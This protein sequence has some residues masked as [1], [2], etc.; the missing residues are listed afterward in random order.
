MYTE[1][2]ERKSQC[3]KSFP[4]TE[5]FDIDFPFSLPHFLTCRWISVLVNIGIADNDL[6][7]V[8][9]ISNWVSTGNDS[10]IFCNRRLEILVADMIFDEIYTA[11]I[12]FCLCLIASDLVF[13]NVFVKLLPHRSRK[14]RIYKLCWSSSIISSCIFCIQNFYFIISLLD[15]LDML[16]QEGVLLT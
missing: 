1:S 8:S 10:I 3:L 15:L 11:R 16:R 4:L 12:P 9:A 2:L 14:S 13:V 7:H 6:L 5:V